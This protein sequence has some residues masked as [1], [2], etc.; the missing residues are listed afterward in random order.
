MRVTVIQVRQNTLFCKSKTNFITAPCPY[1]HTSAPSSHPT[2]KEEQKGTNRGEMSG[3]S[4]KVKEA[5][6]F[7]NQKQGI[8]NRYDRAKSSTFRVQ[9]FNNYVK[10]LLLA[11]FLPVGSHIC[12]LAAGAGADVV[13]YSYYLPKMVTFVDI[14]E[15]A[16]AQ[17][18]TRW[19]QLDNSL[20]HGNS[21]KRKNR[22][23]DDDDHADTEKQ[24]LNSQRY[25]A[26][27]AVLDFIHPSIS[28]DQPIAHVCICNFAMHYALASNPSPPV[29]TGSTSSSVESLCR[30]FRLVSSILSAN[31][32]FW[33]V[34]ADGKSISKLLNGNRNY[35]SRLFEIQRIHTKPVGAINLDAEVSGPGDNNNTGQE[36]KTSELPLGEPYLIKIGEVGKVV[37]ATEYITYE[38]DVEA[39]AKG[40]GMEKKI[41]CPVLLY[42][43][44][45][46]SNRAD[47]RLR[48]IFGLHKK[49]M[50]LDIDDIDL[51]NIYSV[52]LFV[53][54]TATAS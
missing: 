4:N 53:K 19:S 25:E 44:K 26:R 39:M 27:F 45:Y 22:Q 51:L 2:P 21:K 54:S 47:G 20:K 40:F 41:W 37:D 33:G 10:S 23:G 13:K 42:A 16:L 31:G 29:A 11:K 43:S 1:I 46:E 7:Y 24:Q 50:E 35:K 5:K 12:D 52:F 8:Q 49:T 3:S 36:N 48:R 14:A 28:V 38:A 6:E 34:V 30:F 32:R 9:N 18:R 17:C 15:N